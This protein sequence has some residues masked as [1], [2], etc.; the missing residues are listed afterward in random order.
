MTHEQLQD[1]HITALRELVEQRAEI[2]QAR[3]T[4][5]N[6]KLEHIEA[7]KAIERLQ[8]KVNE[9]EADRVIKNNGLRL[10]ARYVVHNLQNPQDHT[11][12]E[13]LGEAREALKRDLPSTTAWLMC[14][15]EVSRRDKNELPQQLFQA[16]EQI[17]RL[18]D[19]VRETERLYK[20]ACKERAEQAQEIAR[21]KAELA[22][23]SASSSYTSGHSAET[24]HQR[25]NV[26]GIQEGNHRES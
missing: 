6:W 9:L 19:S 22:T 7:N 25:C 23:A 24:A 26:D 2:E 8:E 4:G 20:E 21:L 13:I 14:M 5:N 3:R 1:A 11:E 17:E 16:H 12:E 15:M 10:M 18:T